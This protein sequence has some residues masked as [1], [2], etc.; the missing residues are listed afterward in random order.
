M[1]QEVESGFDVYEF[2][3]NAGPG[4]KIVPL[5]RTQVFFSQG[6]PADCVFFLQKGR[7]KIS[8]AS[9]AG[10]EATIRLVSAKDFFGEKAMAA[11]PGLRLTTAHGHNCLHRAQN[12]QARIPPGHA[13]GTV[14]FLLILVVPSS[15]QREDSG[16]PSRPALQ[17]SRKAASASPL[18]F[19]RVQ[20]AGRR[21][22]AD[23]A[24]LTG[25]PRKYDRQY[26]TSRQRIHESISQ[27]GIHRVQ[28]SHSSSQVALK[29]LPSRL[30][31]VRVRKVENGRSG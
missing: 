24:N 18:A 2:L 8:V 10:K 19:G 27:T 21:G 17:P 14:L 28:Q 30:N 11:D 15:L 29:C 5:K 26:Q 9:A 31:C 1:A 12:S 25:S 22:D 4:R 23:F 7:V 3:A 16:R 13:G 6:D 20:P